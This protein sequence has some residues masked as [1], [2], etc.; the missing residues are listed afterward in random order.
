MK[1]KKRQK[2]FYNDKHRN[3][4]WTEEVKGRPISFA[5]KYDTNNVYSDKYEQ[6]K[7]L[8]YQ[9]KQRRK[10][11][12]K[13][14]AKR[15]GALMLAIVLVCCGYIGMDVY[16]T[17]QN[18]P[19]QQMLEQKNAKSNFSQISLNLASMTI[20]SVS[21]DNSTMLDAIIQNVHSAG[22]NSVTF[23]AK[24]PDGTI[25]YQSEL[26]TV[27]TYGAVSNAGSN[28]Q[29]SIKKLNDNDILPV[30]RICCYKDNLLP[31]QDKEYALTVNGKIYK[32][33]KGNT[34][35]NPNSEQ[36]YQ[37]ISDMVKELYRF[38]VRVFLLYD[39]NLPAMDEKYND[40]FEYIS[41]KL[42]EEM[43]YDIKVLEEADVSIR[44]RDLESGR[45]TNSAIK[46]DIKAFKKIRSNQV[47]YVS[48]ELAASRVYS[49]LTENGVEN[50]VIVK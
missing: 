24:R 12:V 49:Q 2:Q 9:T 28:S 37:Y 32:D 33:S 40:G 43:N 11:N 31:N 45:I 19:I 17:R 34:Y 1:K 50:F 36:A 15:I 27:D 47:Y 7:P 38:G 41:N 8:E 22:C 39:C 16:M 26:A 48:T 23:D 29:G 18:V 20:E 21:L 6:T 3:E 35:L 42:L 46:K 30:A 10:A 44:G 14:T 4:H 13:K 5:E 25:G